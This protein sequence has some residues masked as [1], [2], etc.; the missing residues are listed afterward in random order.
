LKETKKYTIKIF[1]FLIIILFLSCENKTQEKFTQITLKD[2]IG[3]VFNFDKLP[4]RIISLAPNITETIYELGADSKLVAITDYCNFP[5]EC[6]TKQ[7]VGGMINPNIEIISSLNPDLILFTIEG[8]SKSTYNYL[9]ENDYKVF[10]TNPRNIEGI[11]KMIMDIGIL[12]NSTDK[13]KDI[14][15]KID[16]IK[17]ILDSINK[18]TSKA[19][20]LFLLSLNPL[21]TVN[22][23]TYIHNILDLA[24]F[25][26][27]Y[28]TIDLPYPEI[29]YEDI[30]LKNPEYIIL[31]TELEDKFG[32]WER[33]LSNKLSTTKAIKENKI[34]VI[35]ADLISRPGPRIIQA[36]LELKNKKDKF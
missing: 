28:A 2:D 29:N 34:F 23:T 8:N 1:I 35:N 9:M 16:S 18:N 27:I 11:M 22:R 14:N 25:E 20:V 19:K 15:K 10:V 26:N 7:S 3:N 6:R 30:L 17:I 5:P 36:L 32:E 33:L 31:T 24:G 21:I 13:A 4:E 12:T